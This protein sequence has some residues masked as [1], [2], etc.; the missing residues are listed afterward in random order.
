MILTLGCVFKSLF[1]FVIIPLRALECPEGHAAHAHY[2][3]AVP[4]TKSKQCQIL[5]LMVPTPH[6]L[7]FW[8]PPLKDIVINFQKWRCLYMSQEI[9]E[10]YFARF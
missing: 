2:C 4:H 5:A 6:T 7:K 3:K 10:T 1:F 8:L 9:L